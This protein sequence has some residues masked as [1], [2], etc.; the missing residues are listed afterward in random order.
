MRVVAT[1]F[2]VV[3]V[4]LGVFLVRPAPVVDLDHKVCDWLAGWAGPGEPSGRVVIVEID[5]KSLAQFGRW[6][7]PRDL[8]SLI[9]RSILDHG[10]SLVVLDMM[11]PQEDRS[12][13]RTT[14]GF[15]QARSGTNDEVLAEALS[16]KPAVV[17]YAFRFDRDTAGP[18]ACSVASLPLAV[19][20]PKDPWGAAFFHATGAV[21][22]VPAISRAAAA[23][24]CCLRCNSRKPISSS[25]SG[26]NVT[27]SPYS[28][29]FTYFSRP[30]A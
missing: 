7:W 12:T 9:A 22:S 27:I 19:A 20:S 29:S 15:G 5:E 10:A 21:C 28:S 25:C 18:P 11:F 13:T 23:K 24:T 1:G 14:G 17:G 8:V 30:S 4:V 6:P 2:A 26:D 16:G 3:L